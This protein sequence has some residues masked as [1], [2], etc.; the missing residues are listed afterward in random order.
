MGPVVKRG[1]VPVKLASYTFASDGFGFFVDVAAPSGR[2]IFRLKLFP[3]D[4]LHTVVDTVQAKTNC[5]EAV[6]KY[7]RHTDGAN[8]NLA[9]ERR[10]RTVFDLGIRRDDELVLHGHPDD[11]VE[12]D[13]EPALPRPLAKSKRH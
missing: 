9:K 4:Q 8:V 3:N 13:W 5:P 12:G 2:H 11:E 1:I 10:G 6:I 7:K